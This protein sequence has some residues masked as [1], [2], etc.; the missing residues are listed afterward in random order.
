MLREISEKEITHTYVRPITPNC[1][2]MY[3]H[4]C[5]C[6]QINENMWALFLIRGGVLCICGSLCDEII[7]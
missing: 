6:V 1:V 2:C 5:V 3:T 4:V 7:H